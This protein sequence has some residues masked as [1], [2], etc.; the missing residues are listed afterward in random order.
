MLGDNF[1]FDIVLSTQLDRRFGNAVISDQD[2]DIGQV[3]ESSR[4]APVEFSSRGR[5][6]SVSMTRT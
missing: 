1:Q 6:V 4:R 3:T 5:R 2:I